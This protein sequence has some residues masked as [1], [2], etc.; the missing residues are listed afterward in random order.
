MTKER[1]KGII[2]RN[3]NEILLQSETVTMTSEM[4]EKNMYI[5]NMKRRIS[6][7][8]NKQEINDID[9]DNNN[10]NH[11]KINQSYN[12][13]IIN[14]GKKLEATSYTNIK[15]SIEKIPKSGFL[16]VLKIEKLTFLNLNSVHLFTKNSIFC[17]LKIMKDNCLHWELITEVCGYVHLYVYM[18][19]YI[20]IFVCIYMY[21]YIYKYTYIHTHLFIFYTL[22]SLLL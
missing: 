14:H 21:I 1:E 17:I 8:I 6:L 3:K 9:I 13:N 10:V 11:S 18:Y 2:Y 7:L 20:C 15:S 12:F 5:E 22:I 16:T 4:V 19:G